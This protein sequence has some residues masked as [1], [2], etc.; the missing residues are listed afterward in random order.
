LKI[1][2]INQVSPR[3]KNV[4]QLLRFRQINNGVLIKLNK[5]TTNMLR[6][7]GA[8]RGSKLQV[9]LELP[10]ALQAEQCSVFSEHAHR[11]LELRVVP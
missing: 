1:R 7:S 3:L 4:L 10:V 8:D 9:R 6:V 5:A 2:G 11:R